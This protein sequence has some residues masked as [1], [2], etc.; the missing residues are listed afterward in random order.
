MKHDAIQYC[1]SRSMFTHQINEAQHRCDI[2]GTTELVQLLDADGHVIEERSIEPNP[3]R[4]IV[5]N[6]WR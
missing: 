1:R 3:N 2:N 4:K 5:R 6:Q